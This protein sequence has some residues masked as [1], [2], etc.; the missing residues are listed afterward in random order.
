MGWSSES[1]RI[2]KFVGGGEEG[3]RGKSFRIHKTF[4]KNY[5]TFG[6]GAKNVGGSKD[7]L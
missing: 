2:R 5:K 3:L 1:F 6:A 4:F 7:F